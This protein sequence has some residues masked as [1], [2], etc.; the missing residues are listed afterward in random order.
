MPWAE[1]ERKRD[2][3]AQ[4]EGV[5]LGKENLSTLIISMS[6]TMY[7]GRGRRSAPWPQ[8]E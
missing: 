6:G 7:G 8:Q 1:G 3:C 4:T 5:P 2:A